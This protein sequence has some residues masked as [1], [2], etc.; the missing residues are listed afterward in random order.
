MAEA[1]DAVK[2]VILRGAGPSF[3]AG[4]DLNRAPVE[5]MGLSPGVRPPQSYRMRGIIPYSELAIDILISVFIITFFTSWIVVGGARGEYRKGNLDKTQSPAWRFKLPKGA[6]LRA[7]VIAMAIVL[8]FGGLFLDG[9]IY[10]ISPAGVSSWVYIVLKI[11]YTGASGALASA[12]TI[13]SI[14][15]DENRS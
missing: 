2:V 7:L 9:L 14:I 1:D 8:V 13:L 3:C 5:G 11:L 10:L 12:L 6:G 15:S 4:D